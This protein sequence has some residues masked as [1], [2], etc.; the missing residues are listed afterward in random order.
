MNQIKT[1]LATLVQ[2]ISDDVERIQQYK[3][4]IPQIEIDILLESIR[5]FYTNVLELNK[6]NI[7]MDNSNSHIVINTLQEAQDKQ[8][9][10]SPVADDTEK[11]ASQEEPAIPIE[12][13]QATIEEVE[14][15]LFEEP[16]AE[17]K[18]NDNSEEAFESMVE[19]ETML[20]DIANDDDILS[21]KSIIEFESVE[22]E[23]PAEEVVEPIAAVVVEEEAK[24]DEVVSDVSTIDIDEKTNTTET[25]GD[26]IIVEDT[27]EPTPAKDVKQP[28]AEPESV[29][30]PKTQP[31]KNEEHEEPRQISL[32]DYLKSSNVSRAAEQVDRFSGVTV[33]TLADKFQESKE[34]EKILFESAHERE[35]QKRRIEDLRT[36]IGI[37]DKILFM[38]DL[39][40]RNMKAYND[41]ILQL[42]KI[43]DTNTALEYLK[44]MEETYKWDK[45]SLA[46]QSFIKIFE[47]KFK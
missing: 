25:E 19:N 24:V 37:N 22:Y 13:P 17:E 2:S 18:N 31:Q 40:D 41:F 33:K 6:V 1:H 26:T 39:F 15:V 44:T 45:E 27:P 36:I 3:D 14:E 34:K 16:V 38:T 4:K 11:Q 8:A 29:T 23:Q 21:P 10:T 47:R 12:E 7:G 28:T 5:E 9:E 30:E 42:N 43:D 46:V 35:P 20:Q 32:F